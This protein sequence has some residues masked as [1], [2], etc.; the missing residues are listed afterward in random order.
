MDITAFVR[1]LA[2]HD[3]AKPLYLENFRHS[4]LGF[5]LLEALGYPDEALVAFAHVIEMERNLRDY[6]TRPGAGAAPAIVSLTYP[7]DRVAAAS[8]SLIAAKIKEDRW[9]H[10]FQNPFTRLTL[11]SEIASGVFEAQQNRERGETWQEWQNLNPPP[12]DRLCQKHLLDILSAAVPELVKDF[13]RILKIT[14]WK[15]SR[16]SRKPKSDSYSPLGATRLGPDELT[17]KGWCNGLL[18]WLEANQIEDWLVAKDAAARWGVEATSG[19]HHALLALLL[20]YLDEYPERTYAA[21]N[22]TALAH[23]TRLAA[24][25]GF[26]VWHNL[27]HAK[28]PLLDETIVMQNGVLW[29]K[30]RNEALDVL[31]GHADNSAEET[32]RDH[33]GLWVTR[34][35]FAGH[36]ALF[37]SAVRL[38]DLHGSR[39]LTDLVR[40]QFKG[41]LARELGVPDL[42]EILPISET[43]FELFY[44]LPSCWPEADIESKIARA[45][46]T[47]TDA[48]LNDPADGLLG[49]LERDFRKATPPLDFRAQAHELRNQLLQLGFGL[50]MVAVRPSS[51]DATIGFKVLANTFGHQLLDAYQESLRFLTAPRAQLQGTMLAMLDEDDRPIGEVCQACLVHPVHEPFHARVTGDPYLQ[52]VTHIFRGEPE[53]LCLS[54]IARRVLSHGYVQVASLEKMLQLDTATDQVTAS[55]RAGL[56]PLPPA[57][58]RQT[59]CAVDD[60]V[61]LGAAFARRRAGRTDELEVFPTVAY[62]ADAESNVALLSLTHTEDLFAEYGYSDLV[63]NWHALP[64]APWRNS[65][66]DTLIQQ[67]E[68]FHQH[69]AEITCAKRHIA[70]VLTRIRLLD[71]FYHAVAPALDNAGIRALPLDQDFPRL[72]VLVPADRLSSAL[73]VLSATLARELLSVPGGQLPDTAAWQRM[74]LRPLLLGSVIVFKQKQAI[75]LVLEAERNLLA[76]LAG[77]SEEEIAEGES[78]ASAE[79]WR[80]LR[81]GFA[82]LRG[83]LTEL[84]AWQAQVTAGNLTEVLRLAGQVDR[85]TMNSFVAALGTPD[86]GQSARNLAEAGL[87]IRAAWLGLARTDVDRLIQPPIYRPLHFLKSMARE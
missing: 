53:A 59:T 51:G 70:R 85:S 21:A 49:L 83:T 1:G 64:A 63:N 80:G 7:L 15:P 68:D 38:D 62:A 16:D 44:L 52:K 32:V 48:V 35:A 31:T 43:P 79:A 41:A 2:W 67:C 69:V 40:R 77:A 27:A 9:H 66:K 24:L 3:I 10:S 71:R 61:D 86:P 73:R 34:I 23:H 36:Q 11:H 30:N 42:A 37:E 28:S 19:G 25:L 57:L 56:P 78:V 4:R 50:R 13:E 46:S 58:V 82:D 84:G 26:V 87:Y 47:A 55:S 20:R 17:L 29:L 39:R 54:C 8:F 14:S 33:L 72:R 6:L 45:F 12:L 75:Y 5:L 65:L 76:R 22:D 74:L 18:E 81:L 60:Y